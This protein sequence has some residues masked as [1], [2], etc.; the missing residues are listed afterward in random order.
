LIFEKWKLFEFPTP[1]G[2][3]PTYYIGPTHGRLP[4][5]AYNT[6]QSARAALAMRDWIAK[7]LK[8]IEH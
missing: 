3:T 5:A 6:K 1:K 2:K 4:M 7:E 8:R